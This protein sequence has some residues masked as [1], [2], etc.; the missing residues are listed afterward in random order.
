MSNRL[1]HSVSENLQWSCE[2]ERVARKAAI[3]WKMHQFTSVRDVLWGNAVYLKEANAI[4]I[5]LNKKVSGE[6]K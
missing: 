1:I 2:E 3:K 6:T 4:S 5:E